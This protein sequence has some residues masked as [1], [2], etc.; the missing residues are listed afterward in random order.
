MLLVSRWRE[1]EA[2]GYGCAEAI[3]R[4]S[5]ERLPAILMTALSSALALV[6]LALGGDKP[7]NEIQSPM[8]LVILGGL[9]TSTV[10][11]GLVLPVVWAWV[12][13]RSHGGGVLGLV[14]G[15]V[16]LLGAEGAGAQVEVK[17]ELEWPGVYAVRGELLR[18]KGRGVELEAAWTAVE[19]EL[20]VGEAEIELAYVVK[21]LGLA[22]ARLAELEGLREGLERGEVGAIEEGRLGMEVSRLSGEVE[23]LE[24]ERRG[25]EEALG[26]LR[27]LSLQSRS[28]G[29]EG[30]AG[31]GGAGLR[32]A[33]L[34]QEV[35]EAE[36]GLAE[37]RRQRWPGMEVG[38]SGGV[39]KGEVGSWGVG[40]VVS[41]WGQ[42]QRVK[43][44]ELAVRGARGRQEVGVVR[45]GAEVAGLRGKVSGLG[46]SMEVL[47]V[48]L[49]GGR[50]VVSKARVGLEG[51]VMTLGEYVRVSGEVYE[52][53]VRYMEVE[54]AY[55]KGALR[56]GMVGAWR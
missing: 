14:L 53:E 32:E 22:E 1:L 17:G 50:E 8:A 35:R 9:L 44:A 41:L 15:G 23:V 26:V 2:E 38:Y 3:R 31:G 4:G 28:H 10:L 40:I 18:E 16:L 6:P 43:G 46:R 11:N 49:A 36:L 7:G 42:R 54:A 27:T 48:G 30:V 25:L 51:G 21:R 56:E 39:G 34:G 24:G 12:K 52:L 47:E 20:E 19:V 13:G 29:G 55:K 33:L 45:W 5:S 37:A